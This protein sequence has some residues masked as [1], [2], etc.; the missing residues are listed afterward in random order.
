MEKEFNYYLITDPDY[1]TNDIKLFEKKLTDVLRSKRVDIACFRDKKSENYEELAKVFVETCK[2]F[3]IKKTLLN[4]NLDLAIKLNTGVHLTSTQFDKIKIAK[5]TNLF[6]IIS[7]HNEKDIE[8]AIKNKADAITYSP[9]FNTPNKGEPKG[10]KKLKEIKK[11]YNINIIALGGIVSQAQIKQIEEI[12]I[13]GFA[14]IR[15]FI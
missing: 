1:Y 9:I 8:L 11:N 3:N 7:C 10:I 15:Y 13:Y 6:T 5:D 4:E 2:K 12:D 14:S